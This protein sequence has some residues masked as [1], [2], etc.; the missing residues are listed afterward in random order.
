VFPVI[1]EIC[2]SLKASHNGMKTSDSGISFGTGDAPDLQARS[3]TQNIQSFAIGFQCFQQFREICFSLE[4]IPEPAITRGLG[5]V[6]V[7]L[8]GS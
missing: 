1:W 8:M 3:G 7:Q 6:L 4:V 2:F 5:T